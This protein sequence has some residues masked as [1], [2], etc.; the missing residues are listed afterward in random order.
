MDSYQRLIDKV[1]DLEA[2]LADLK[3]EL[4]EYAEDTDRDR[5]EEDADRRRRGMHSLALLPAV[6]AGGVAVAKQSPMA[7]AAVA[8][9]ASGIIGAVVLMP[10]GNGG[11]PH[12]TAPGV[13]TGQQPPAQTDE[14]P[15]RRT[16]RRPEAAPPV[17]V[18]PP[19]TVPDVQPSALALTVDL[20]PV[21][22]H[23]PRH[24]AKKAQAHVASTTKA[25]KPQ[26]GGIKAKVRL[27]RVVGGDVRLCRL[28][29]PPLQP[30]MI[31]REVR[32][33]GL[34]A[35]GPTAR[36]GQ[37]RHRHQLLENSPPAGQR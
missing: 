1:A 27:V 2:E 25:A 13:I 33:A 15:P 4:R 21:R 29:V 6:V 9:T 35:T 30:H 36:R 8:L 32:I 31:R 26:A 17:S 20:T 7:S 22:K 24:P 16:M 37:D 3:L 34:P 23:P 11:A 19:R 18:R 5:A 28:G 12:D 14:V 10:P